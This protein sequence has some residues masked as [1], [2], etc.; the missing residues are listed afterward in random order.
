MHS[1]ERGFLATAYRWILHGEDGIRLT[2]KLLSPEAATPIA[3]TLTRGPFRARARHPA[4]SLRPEK[5]RFVWHGRHPSGYGYIRIV[6]FGGRMEIA[7]EF[8]VALEA[9]KDTPGLVID[10]RDSPGG[11]G[12]AQPRIVGRFIRARTPVA[13]SYR[14]SRPG[15][16]EF[17]KRQTYFVPSGDWQ[18]T[19]PVALLLN[20]VTGSAADLFACCLTSTGRPITIGTTTHGNLPGVGV[21]VVLPCDL[22]VRVSSGYACDAAGRPIESRGNVVQIEAEQSIADVV[23]GTDSVLE[24]AI[25]E[26]RKRASSLSPYSDGRRASTGRP[27]Q[28]RPS[29]T[30]RPQ[31]PPQP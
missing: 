22:V 13:V 8:D 17:R 10:I 28:L 23:N 24:R 25:E 9:L 4:P 31:T 12:H 20:A 1:S 11:F 16:H 15:H 26:L 27:D 7:D 29:S 30:L 2:L 3:V 18:Y 6:S 19:K 21:Y 14:K 5:G